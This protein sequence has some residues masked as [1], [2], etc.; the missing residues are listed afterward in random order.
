MLIVVFRESIQLDGRV[1]ELERG[2]H[3]F[4]LSTHVSFSDLKVSQQNYLVFII[5]IFVAGIASIRLVSFKHKYS[6]FLNW[7]WTLPANWYF[8]GRDIFKQHLMPALLLSC[9][10]CQIIHFLNKI[11]RDYFVS[12][13]FLLLR[14]K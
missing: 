8:T 5:V 4:Q 7:E 12:S 3:Y 14:E 10:F 2:W 6:K 9:L 13:H 11:K 1:V